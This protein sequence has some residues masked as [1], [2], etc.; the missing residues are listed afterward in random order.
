MIVFSKNR[1]RYERVRKNSKP[2]GE[3]LNLDKFI[4]C[5]KEDFIE[6]LNKTTFQCLSF[7]EHNIFKTKF[8]H[9]PVCNA[10][11]AYRS[12]E[13]FLEMIDNYARSP[14]K[15]MQRCIRPCIIGDVTYNSAFAKSTGTYIYIYIFKSLLN[16]VY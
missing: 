15:I 4:D 16:V 1:K 5:L 9:Y 2:C 8:P 7:Y 6:R 14:A 10:S 12:H 11:Q 3:G 13:L